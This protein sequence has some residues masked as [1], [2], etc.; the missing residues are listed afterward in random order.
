MLSEVAEPG[1]YHAPRNLDEDETLMARVD[2]LLFRAEAR[3][4]YVR[5]LHADDQVLLARTLEELQ[6]WAQ[7]LGGDT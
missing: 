6:E 3:R 4:Q 5:A 2:R 1:H 7:G